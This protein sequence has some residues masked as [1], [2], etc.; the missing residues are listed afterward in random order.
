MSVITSDTFQAS[1][2]YAITRH[3]FQTMLHEALMSN[4]DLQCFGLLGAGHGGGISVIALVNTSEKLEKTTA[5]WSASDTDCL[6]LFH[7]SGMSVPDLLLQAVPDTYIDVAISLGEKGRLDIFA[8]RRDKSQVS[9]DSEP[10]AI[11]LH[12]IEDGHTPRNA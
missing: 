5:V 2:S 11:T 12:L 6:G 1:T 3:V 4:A 10:L 9:I 8:T 7:I